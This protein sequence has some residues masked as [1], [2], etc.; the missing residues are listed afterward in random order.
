VCARRLLPSPRSRSCR[1]CPLSRRDWRCFLPF[2]FFFDL[3]APRRPLRP[4][5]RRRPCRPRRVIVVVGVSSSVSSCPPRRRQRPRGP[6][7]PRCPRRPRR[8]SCCG[9]SLLLWSLLPLLVLTFLLV[10]L[11]ATRLN[12]FVVPALPV[13]NSR[14]L[15]RFGDAAYFDGV[16]ALAP[17][18]LL[19]T[20][21]CRL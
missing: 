4:R 18:A 16:L 21:R 3:K 13:W 19:C 7:D 10:C 8:P 14:V 9:I 11:S 15:G 17:L 5:R 1:S 20:W 12:V 6:Q 2:F